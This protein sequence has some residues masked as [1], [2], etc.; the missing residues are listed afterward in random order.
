M[1]KYTLK[2][3]SLI[4]IYFAFFVLL[5]NFLML[6]KKKKKIPSYQKAIKLIVN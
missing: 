6:Y 3:I 1:S 4:K 2:K 5:F